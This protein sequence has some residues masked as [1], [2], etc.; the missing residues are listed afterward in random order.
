M[1]WT[2]LCVGGKL[3][4]LETCIFGTKKVFVDLAQ[5]EISLLEI[6]TGVVNLKSFD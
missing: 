5:K 4:E 6:V 3:F 2:A 1:L